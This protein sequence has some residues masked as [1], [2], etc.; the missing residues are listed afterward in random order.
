LTHDASGSSPPLAHALSL[1]AG[2]D[3]DGEA[4]PRVAA[5]VYLPPAPAAARMALV[6]LAGGNMNRGYYDLQVEGD[7]GFSF[8]AQMTAR[9]FV[10]VTVDL[11]GLGGSTRPADGYA[12]TTE[13]IVRANARATGE[14]LDRLRQGRLDARVPAL[15]ALRSVG[16]GHSM[17]AMLSVVQQAQARQHAGL[18]LLG[19]STRGLPRFVPE[20]VR[21]LAA[22]DMAALRA[23]LPEFARRMFVVPYP[24]IRRAGGSGDN[25][26][27]YGSAGADPR[28]VAAL[29]A[30]TDSLL[31]V[32]AFQSMVPGN[33]AAEAAQLDVPVLLMLGEHDMAGPPA[34]APRAF[35]RS[36]DVQLEVLPGA[37]HSHF[38]FAA[39]AQLFERLAAW[40][41]ALPA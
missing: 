38:L 31:P 4:A 13:V 33:V 6:C 12:L 16:V 41:D 32:P 10:V 40:A 9:G 14:I 21:A 26:A 23:R 39:R 1:E 15:P 29:K 30:A 7:R 11:L 19:F 34:E 24:R 35:T 17:G 37:G 27:L 5:T 25:A 36:P 28:G 18:A 2:V 8:A 3:L 22:T 20:D